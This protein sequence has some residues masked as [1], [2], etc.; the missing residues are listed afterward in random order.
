M[1]C[2]IDEAGRGS[3]GGSLFVCGVAYPDE[4][5]PSL[6][7]LKI[8][9]SKKLFLLSFVFSFIPFVCNLVSLI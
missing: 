6:S 4:L 5:I 3:V 8:K 2:G 9:D 1:I 7:H